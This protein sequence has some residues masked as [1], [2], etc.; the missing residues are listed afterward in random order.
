MTVTHDLVNN[1]RNSECRLCQ[2]AA[3]ELERLRLQL[4]TARGLLDTAVD[5]WESSGRASE[6]APGTTIWLP[7]PWFDKARELTVGE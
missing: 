7:T 4:H 6:L 3:D 1:L 5:A 2:V